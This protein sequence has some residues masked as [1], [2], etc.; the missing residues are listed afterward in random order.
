MA[1]ETTID[2][3]LLDRTCRLYFL[4]HHF[5]TSIAFFRLGDEHDYIMMQI[6]R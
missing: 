1:I 2:T 6:E 3:L 5:P 4:N